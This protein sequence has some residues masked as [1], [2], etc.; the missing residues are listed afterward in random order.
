MQSQTKLAPIVGRD[1][2]QGARGGRR[3]EAE[4]ATVEIDT[5]LARVLG[6][7]EGL[8]VGHSHCAET[9]DGLTFSRYLSFYMWIHLWRILFTLNQ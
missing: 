2:I 8:K 1:G 3:P 9:G 6:I 5:T 4:C 7:N